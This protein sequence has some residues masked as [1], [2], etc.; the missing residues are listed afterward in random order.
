MFAVTTTVQHP[1]TRADNDIRTV[2]RTQ[3]V[4]WPGHSEYL[5]GAISLRYYGQELLD[6]ADDIYALWE[7][8][9]ETLAEY[10][11]Q[12]EAV[13]GFPDQPLELT[14]KR[15]TAGN[16]LYVLGSTR[17]AVSEEEF[18]TAMLAGAME[19]FTWTENERMQCAV[20]QLQNRRTN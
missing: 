18:L 3:C 19:F 20:R 9:T 11:E 4:Q 1:K 5:Q 15:L 10:M 7:A 12:G 6:I 8:V 16:L 17:L 13:C 2:P 14:L